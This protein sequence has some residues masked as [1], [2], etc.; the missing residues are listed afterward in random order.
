LCTFLSQAL[1][2]IGIIPDIRVFQFAV[3]LDQAI[4]PILI[5]KDTP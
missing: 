4:F 3:N 1:G 5:V 2:A